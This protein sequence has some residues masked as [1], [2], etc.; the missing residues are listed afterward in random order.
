MS[1]WEL[2]ETCVPTRLDAV[3]TFEVSHGFAGCGELRYLQGTSS[4][5]AEV[6]RGQVESR[7]CGVGTDYDAESLFD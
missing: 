1:R 2:S 7:E 6:G 5:D 3:S 4:W